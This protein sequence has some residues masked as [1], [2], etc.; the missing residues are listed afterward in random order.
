MPEIENIALREAL[1]DFGV[2]DVL[3]GEDI[4]LHVGKGPEG[5]FV[6]K[7]DRAKELVVKIQDA[8]W[9]DKM[10]ELVKQAEKSGL[11]KGGIYKVSGRKLWLEVMNKFSEAV[12]LGEYEFVRGDVWASHKVDHRS[13]SDAPPDEALE[14]LCREAPEKALDLVM[15][16]LAR[17]ADMMNEIV[18]ETRRDHIEFEIRS[19]QIDRTLARTREILDE[20]IGEPR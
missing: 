15:D 3:P 4:V 2:D 9:D 12:P 8:R 7:A 5:L 17:S 18:E 20:L 14:A 6:S 13:S 19:R 11:G 1:K 10:S 16:S